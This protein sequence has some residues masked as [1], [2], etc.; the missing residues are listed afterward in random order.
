MLGLS[1]IKLEFF[2]RFWHVVSTFSLLK[3]FFI[4]VC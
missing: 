4:N 2:K 1:R 3:M